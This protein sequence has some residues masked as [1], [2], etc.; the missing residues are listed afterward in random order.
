MNDVKP[1]KSPNALEVHNCEVHGG[2]ISIIKI[3][4]PERNDEEHILCVSCIIDVL[5]KNGMKNLA[6]ETKDVH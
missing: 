4:I 2:V 1:V 6:K 3:K 5:Y